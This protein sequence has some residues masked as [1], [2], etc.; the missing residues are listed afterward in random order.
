MKALLILA[1]SL[2]SVS[3]SAESI[4]CTFTEPFLTVTYNSE[5]NKIRV[6]SAEHGSAET[7]AHVIFKSGGILH[8]DAEG[9]T[10]YLEVNLTKEGSDGMSD[11]IYPFE[12]KISELLVGGCETDTLKKR[13]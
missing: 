13:Q 11:A 9:I 12:G 1:L 5:T 4:Y 6:D 8:I 10:Q 7:T 3:A 2:M